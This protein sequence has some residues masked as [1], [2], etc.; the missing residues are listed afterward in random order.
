MCAFSAAFRARFRSSIRSSASSSPIDSRIVPGVM[1]ACAS[2]ASSMRKCVVDAGWITSERQ[3]PTLARCEKIFSA[4]M[5][6]LPCEREPLRSKLNTAP[7]PR[8]SSALA[9]AWL[10]WPFELRVADGRDQRLRG[11]ELHHLARVLDV[12][13]HAQRQRLD[14]LQ[15]QPRGVRAHAGAEVAQALAARAQQE[16]AVGALLAEHH[17]VEALVGLVEFGESRGLAPVEAPAVDQHATDHRAV[18][19]E[20]LGRRVEDQVG[21]VLERLHQPGRREGRV[22]EQRNAGV[23]GDRAD[24]RDVEHVQP[25]VAERL[26]EQQL[27][28]RAGSPRAS[29]RCRPA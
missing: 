15:H 28:V 17:A 8:G 14:A 13:R 11:E 3:S 24:G 21:A 12:A 23:V 6:A 5:K 27:R 16:G 18:A 9:S 4:S 10:A 25:R 29:R 1:P 20:E 22:D 2:A 7:A 19:A 26:A